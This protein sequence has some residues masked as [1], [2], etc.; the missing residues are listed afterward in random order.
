MADERALVIQ[1]DPTD[2]VGR[3]GGWLAD[4]GLAPH[5]VREAPDPAALDGY[6]ALVVL[7]GAASAHESSLRPVRALLARAAA[8]ELPTLGICLGAQLLALALGGRVERNPEGPEYGARLVAKRS[9]AATD[10]LFRAVPIT[11]DVLQ[12]HVDAVTELPPGAVQLAAGPVCDVQAFRVG[13]LAWG[14]QFHI[15]TTPEMVRGWARTDSDAL[16]DYDI[17]EILARAD[18]AHADIAQTWE[19]FAVAFA[20][21][22]RHPDPVGS[23]QPP[24]LR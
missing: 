19:P 21:V 3:L 17:E 18:A 15:E 11:P 20:D 7:G 22:A 2:P 14:L 12:W 23:P 6:A 16:A 4:A 1:N 10:P 9:A 24:G 8:R 5:V 13:R